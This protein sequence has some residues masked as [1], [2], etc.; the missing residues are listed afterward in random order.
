[1][2]MMKRQ[3]MTEQKATAKKSYIK[4]VLSILLVVL[5]CA[6]LVAGSVL[7]RGT[8]M[9]AGVCLMLI[10][11]LLGVFSGKKNRNISSDEKFPLEEE[12]IGNR[13]K[14][15]EI[16]A[17]IE[18]YLRQHKMMYEEE[19]VLAQLQ[20][21]LN[22][23]LIYEN[24]GDRRK[25]YACEELT[26][27]IQEKTAMLE[28]IL[29][30]FTDII[31][32]DISFTEK[33]QMLMQTC[34]KYYAEKEKNERNINAAERLKES[35][36]AVLTFLQEI[37]VK[38]AEEDLL[39]NQLQ[40]LLETVSVYNALSDGYQ[41]AKKKKEDYESAYNLE[42]I[43]AGY[44]EEDVISLQELQEQFVLLEEEA[45]QIRTRMKTYEEQ[46][47]V[48]HEQY[49]EWV[50]TKEMLEIKQAEQ[51][52]KKRQ[53]ELLGKTKEFLGRAK[54]ALTARYTGPIM[55]HFL[56]YY[57]VVTGKE[58]TSYHM[59]ANIRMTREEQGLQRDVAFLSAGYQDLTGVCLRLALVD[60]MYTDEKP[61]LIMDDPFVNLD[62]ENSVGSKRLMDELAKT[63]QIIYFTCR[64][65]R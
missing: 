26:G 57:A 2:D 28:K 47:N 27:D 7:V 1:L 19:T 15:E 63:Y 37:G 54:E 40:Y 46:L 30:P 65:M 8:I 9:G 4:L 36:F 48:L 24:L 25:R 35:R 32:T 17:R 38:G 41:Q 53:Y 18:S 22:R 23:A 29:L 52:D 16:G 39:R 44:K 21:L 12:I 3:H 64:E 43:L 59:D 55:E 45:E 58:D 20:Q 62:E 11:A 14:V 10:G 49:D 13:K 33:V 50:A 34:E 61:M 51:I 56:R 5:G 60:A 42:E 31:P 6:I